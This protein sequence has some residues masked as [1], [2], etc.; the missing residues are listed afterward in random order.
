MRRLDQR[1]PHAP[2]RARL[3]FRRDAAGGCGSIAEIDLVPSR[4]QAQLARVRATPS[5]QHVGDVYPRRP[6]TL[7]KVAWIVE[8]SEDGIRNDDSLCRARLK[9]PAGCNPPSDFHQSSGTPW[10]H[11]A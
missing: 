7:M 10:V 8:L 9:T 5:Q 2:R 4:L 6:G 1:P 11:V 3:C